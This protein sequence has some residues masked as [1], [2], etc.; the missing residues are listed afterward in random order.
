LIILSLVCLSRVVESVITVTSKIPLLQIPLGTTVTIRT[1]DY[2]VDSAGGL[3]I[4]TYSNHFLIL[5]GLIIDM[6]GSIKE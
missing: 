3:V 1:S 4:F 5:I 2:A 6:N